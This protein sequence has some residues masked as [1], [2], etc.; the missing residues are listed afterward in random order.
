[1]AGLHNYTRLL[2]NLSVS[3]KKANYMRKTKD[4]FAARSVA[5]GA[6]CKNRAKGYKRNMLICFDKADYYARE[7]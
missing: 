2:K 6:V 1:V 4:P 7:N 5:I 3:E